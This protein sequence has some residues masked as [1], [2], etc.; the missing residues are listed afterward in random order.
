M[1]PYAQSLVSE[2]RA[3]GYAAEAPWPT[4]GGCEQIFVP[5]GPLEIGITNGDAAL[6]D[7]DVHDG[8]IAYVSADDIDGDEIDAISLPPGASI[9]DAV[10]RL[11]GRL[12]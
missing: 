9:V 12:T 10:A 8:L 4:G 6:P 7:G 1:N 11:V 3:A 5:V 2:L